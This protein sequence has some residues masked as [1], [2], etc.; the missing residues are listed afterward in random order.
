MGPRE[1]ILGVQLLAGWQHF[2]LENLHCSSG[3]FSESFKDQSRLGSWVTAQNKPTGN[4]MGS[5][6][7]QDSRDC[8]IPNPSAN[9]PVVSPFNHG[10]RL[11]ETQRK[12][13]V[14]PTWTPNVMG[15]GWQTSLSQSRRPRSW[16]LT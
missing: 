7:S 4:L 15:P 13:E 1:W 9:L 11:K 16:A 2:P 12:E 6:M 10:P 3:S 14:S 5:L 8:H